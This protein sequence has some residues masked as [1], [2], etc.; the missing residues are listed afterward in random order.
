[1]VELATIISLVLPTIPPRSCE[2]LKEKQSNTRYAYMCVCVQTAGMSQ[3]QHQT[4]PPPLPLVE[5]VLPEGGLGAERAAVS[6]RVRDD[7]FCPDRRRV[8]I[9]VP[10]HAQTHTYTH[11]QTHI[12]YDCAPVRT[13]V[14]VFFLHFIIIERPVFDGW[15]P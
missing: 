12:A 9:D 5:C 7:L 14:F 2:G 11:T 4:T 10:Q 1:M 3:V 13:T 15:C 6:V 8:P